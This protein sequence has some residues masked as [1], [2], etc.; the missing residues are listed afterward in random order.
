M[1]ILVSV[2]LLGSQPTLDDPVEDVVQYI[3]DDVEIHRLSVVLGI[4]ILPFIV[5]FFAAMV[6][7]LR[8][9]DREHNE[10]WGIAL[11]AGAVFIGATA[12]IGDTITGILFL[13]GGEELDDS[14]VRAL[15][16]GLYIAYV[17]TGI[18]IAAATGS[19]AIAAIQREFWPP[20]Y[21]WLSA[22]VAVIGL[23]SVG[24][25]MWTSTTGLVL[26]AVPLPAPGVWILA[27]SVLLY[28]EG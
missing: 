11:L 5:V 23:I 26:G 14:T 17:S 22:L 20:W 16:D 21:G 7:K 19:V 13:R 12:A 4:L 25:I 10:A 3:G 2:A 6:S 18:A 15:F 1:L 9:G 28:R 24:G 27:S 8:D